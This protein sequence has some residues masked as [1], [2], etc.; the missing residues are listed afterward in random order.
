[1][2]TNSNSD[3]KSIIDFDDEYSENKINENKNNITDNE[4]NNINKSGQMNHPK[5]DNFQ[6]EED[7]AIAAIE[8]EEEENVEEEKEIIN[9]P[10]VKELNEIDINNKQAII[11]FLMQDNLITKKPIKKEDFMKD[12]NKNKYLYVNSSVKKKTTNGTQK[13][14]FGRV[15]YQIEHEEGDPQFVKDINVA[16]NLLKDQIQEENKDVAKLLFDDI[17]PNLTTKKIITRKEIGEKVQKALENKRKNLERIEKEMYQEQKSIETFTP[18]INHKANEGERR[19]LQTFLQSQNDFQKRVEEKKNSLLV[20]KEEEIK[21]INIGKPKINKHSE[22]LSKISNGEPVYMRLYNKR[23]IKEKKEEEE[24]KENNQKKEEDKKRKEK[25]QKKNNPYSHIRSK[26]NILRKSP[27]QAGGNAIKD[28]VILSKTN[29]KNNSKVKIPFDR[30]SKSLNKRDK[31]ESDIFRNRNKKLFDIK[32]LPTNKMLWSKFIKD[33]DEALINLNEDNNNMEENIE[34]LD[35]YQ[36]HK[37]LFLLCLVTYPPEQKENEQKNENNKQM[38]VIP[39]TNVES[40][41]KI[42][43]NNLINDSFNL[44]KLDQD[45]VKTINIRNFLMFVL[46]NQNYDLYQQYKTNH[47]QELK[48]LFPTDKFKKEEIPELILK[49]QNEQLLSNVDKSN[50]KNNKYFY[51]SHDNKIIFTLDKSNNIKKDFSMFSLNYRN[52]RRKTKEDQIINIIKQQYPFKPTINVRSEKLYQKYKDKVYAIH[53]DTVTSNN[54][55]YKKES[56]EYIDRILLLDKR[57][58][59]EN[60][61]IKEEL[62]KKETKECTFKPKINQTYPLKKKENKENFETK[63]ENKENNENKGNNES[64]SINKKNNSK[65][66]SRFDQLYEHG[67]K[68][69][70]SKKNKSREEIELERQKNECTFQPNIKNLNAQKIPLTKFTNDIYNEKEYKYLYERLKHGR[71]ERMVKDSNNDRYGLNNE[72]KQFVKD[73]KEFNYIQ[74]QAY[75]EPENPYYYN[76]NQNDFENNFNNETNMFQDETMNETNI[77]ND[78]EEED[79]NSEEGAPEKK[80]EIP[81]LIIDVNIRQGVKK[82][83]FVYEGDTPEE[84]ADKF[85]KKHNLDT[86]TKNKLQSLIQ[87]HMV[88][89]LTKIEEENQSSKSQN[90]QNQK[91]L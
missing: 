83:I 82:K 7:Q 25:S 44:L 29:A 9:D 64:N 75:F 16:A 42:D 10:K 74:N 13:N 88:K 49:K 51:V 59:A 33:F 77:R 1:M 19:D 43:E 12:Q 38:E 34:E 84:L 69:I 18:A 37:L 31:S 71:L 50:K 57:R 4:N 3:E 62:L 85:A 91:I 2:D 86:E 63:N 90:S 45:K 65:N 17:T 15:G 20:K 8:D 87:S 6:E 14:S 73:N 22:Q 36:Y 52:K 68:Y 66:K 53:S 23:N 21:K 60:Q 48:D 81:M 80:D 47:E 41:I 28:E 58:L 79:N 27:S 67:K 26:I 39:E 72:L 46:D 89:L 54:S 35:L 61:K 40:M 56:M 11:D 30:N 70:Q 76:N 32:D 24:K 78:G 5:N 55:Q